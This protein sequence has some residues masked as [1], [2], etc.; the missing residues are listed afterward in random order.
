MP[1]A[2]NLNNLLIGATLGTEDR[3]D[4]CIR[5]ATNDLLYRFV[6]TTKNQEQPLDE[7][8]SVALGNARSFAQ[9]DSRLALGAP[10]QQARALLEILD[11]NL[12]TLTG[13]AAPPLAMTQ[14]EGIRSLVSQIM[15]LLADPSISAA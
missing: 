9:F 8:L 5:S 15:P 13:T 4:I 6:P 1:E 7:V 11:R 2:Q 3:G 14:L 12:E 10:M